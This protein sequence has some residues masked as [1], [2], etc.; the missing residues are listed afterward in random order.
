MQQFLQQSN[1]WALRAIA[2]RLLEAADRGM[3]QQPADATLEA[4]REV[5]LQAEAFVEAQGERMRTTP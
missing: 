5:R 2:D 3:W 4:L 1:P